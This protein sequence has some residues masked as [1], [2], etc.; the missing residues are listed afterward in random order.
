MAALCIGDSVNSFSRRS[1]LTCYHGEEDKWPPHNEAILRDGKVMV[2]SMEKFYVE[3][4]RRLPLDKIPELFNCIC[5]A[6]H[7]IGLADPVSNII[8]NAIS[9]LSS[10]SPSGGA[11]SPSPPRKRRH[12]TSAP[13]R[14]QWEVSP[15]P[16]TSASSPSWLNTYLTEIQA[17]RYLHAASYDLS[18]AIK[19]V[20]HERSSS[21]SQRCL[22]PDGG[23]I[24]AALRIAALQAGHPAADDLAGLVTAHLGDVWATRD[25]L[26]SQW[27]P[28]PLPNLDIL[29]HPNGN[30]SV[31]STVDSVLLLLS[32]CIGDDLCAQISMASRRHLDSLQLGYMSDLTFDSPY[33]E[34]KLSNFLVAAARMRSCRLYSTVDYDGI[35]CEHILSLKMC[36]L[37]SIHALY[38]KAL[39]IVPIS[40][41]DFRFLRA[42]L[43]A[44]HC[45]G[46]MDPVSNIILNSLS[47]MISPSP[48]VRSILKHIMSRWETRSLNGLVALFRTSHS[49]SL[50]EHEILEHLYFW[51]CDLSRLCKEV[52][53]DS[54]PFAD[55]AKAAKHP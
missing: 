55:V 4:A 26:K 42:L 54:I 6:G 44:G 14:W 48:C 28:T 17:R 18:L 41:G 10:P 12:R 13:G 5:K 50:S 27:P 8:L 47:G 19:L 37:D 49:S 36:L 40:S 30:T 43:I 11:H 33:M 45:Y 31:Q 35:K 9:Q 39:T 22:L 53:R 52:A 23:K 1:R 24:K 7:C 51:N 25:L 32:S 2:V 16:P 34:T 46:P 21:K 15:M 38:I 29:C 20:L 3:A